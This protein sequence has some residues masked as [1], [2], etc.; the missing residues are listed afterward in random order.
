VGGAL[1]ALSRDASETLVVIAPNDA[2]ARAIFE[3]V[4]RSS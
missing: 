1:T 3:R 2:V 4:T